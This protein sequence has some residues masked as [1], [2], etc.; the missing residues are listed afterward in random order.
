MYALCLGAKLFGF[1]DYVVN[2]CGTDNSMGIVR[3]VISDY[4]H[5]VRIV[6]H[7]KNRGLS[8]A[9]NTG[10]REATGDYLFFM[11]SDDYLLH[12]D[13]LSHLIK[14]VL[15]YPEVDMV[16]GLTQSE[17]VRYV[18]EKT[19]NMNEVCH[20]SRIIKKMML[21]DKSLLPA[22]WNKLIKKEWV[23]NNRLFFK[24]GIV[25]EDRHWIYY[26]AK[27]VSTIAI[28]KTY[29]YFYRN[30]PNGIMRLQRQKMELWKYSLDVIVRDTIAHIDPY[31]MGGQLCFILRTT[32][33]RCLLGRDD[34]SVSFVTHLCRIWGYLIGML[35]RKIN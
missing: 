22:V 16:L 35:F 25:S 31:C 21:N 17:E 27:H 8:A 32:N 14:T 3:K 2:D 13:S 30:N 12:P 19:Q 10:I 34:R 28:C 4:N 18:M 15:K 9:R 24:E 11:D 33:R 1:G 5:E 26:A 20:S 7:T 6:A 29:T 23:I